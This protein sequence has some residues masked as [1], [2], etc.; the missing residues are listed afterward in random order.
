MFPKDAFLQFMINFFA[1]PGTNQSWIVLILVISSFWYGD[2]LDKGQKGESME[3]AA[4]QEM[5]AKRG[6]FHVTSERSPSCRTLL[7][8]SLSSRCEVNMEHWNI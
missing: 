4:S 3:A 2:M 5:L 6:N 8:A 1:L 7:A